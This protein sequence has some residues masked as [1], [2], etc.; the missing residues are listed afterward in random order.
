MAKKELKP[1]MLVE[2]TKNFSIVELT[3]VDYMNNKISYE[4]TEKCIEF[5][6][7]YYV[8]PEN[9]KDLIGCKHTLSFEEFEE[10]FLPFD[11][12]KYEY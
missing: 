7:F 4:V 1:G 2:N 8:D 10:I 3:E 9:A 5:M 6:E 12:E 11:P